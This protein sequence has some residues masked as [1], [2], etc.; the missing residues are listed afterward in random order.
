MRWHVLFLK[1]I[2]NLLFFTCI[3]DNFLTLRR[4]S[5]KYDIDNGERVG[6]SEKASIKNNE[7]RL[8]WRC[9]L[10]EFYRLIIN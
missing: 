5:I 9:E 4:V 8:F 2:A 1:E 7:T 10:W 6:G 3:V